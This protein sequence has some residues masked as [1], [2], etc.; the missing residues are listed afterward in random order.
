MSQQAPLSKF[1]ARCDPSALP[2]EG[3]YVPRV[4][5][6]AARLAMELEPSRRS[7]VLL[8]GQTG[9]GKS[10]E[11]ARLAEMLEESY[12]IVVCPPVDKV[13][14]LKGVSWHELLV[15][16]ALWATEHHRK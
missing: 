2:P 11:L 15:F 4:P 12:Y 6:F 3:T 8:F 16:S 5:N 10:T 1:I 13:L 9:V 14:D 7:R